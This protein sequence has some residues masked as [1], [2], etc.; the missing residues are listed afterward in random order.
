MVGD[1]LYTCGAQEND[2]WVVGRS[3]DASTQDLCGELIW[4]NV[5]GPLPCPAPSRVE[6]TCDP[7]WPVVQVAF[8][9]APDGG[10]SCFSS[11]DGGT[12]PAKPS[13]CGCQSG[14]DGLAGLALVL[15]IACMR[16]RLWTRATSE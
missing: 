1:S 5:R 4:Q 3:S 16:S 14:G 6:S 2:G 7:I 10:A 8:A 9:P 13:S 11:P 12:G 15:L